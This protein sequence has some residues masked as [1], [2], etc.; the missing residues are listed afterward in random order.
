MI[1]QRSS[2]GSKAILGLIIVLKFLHYS[3][4]MFMVIQL[5]S[6]PGCLVP[7]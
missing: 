2:N 4:S 3:R 7:S 1:R 5:I 6:E